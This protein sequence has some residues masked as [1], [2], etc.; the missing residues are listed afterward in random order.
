MA[1][2]GVR[3]TQ[4]HHQPLIMRLMIQSHR[5]SPSGR[6]LSASSLLP[7]TLFNRAP[8]RWKRRHIGH[9]HSRS[10]I[11]KLVSWTY[12]YILARP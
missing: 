4:P 9:A 3:A 12:V 10:I 11:W 5:L 7:V 2:Q 8:E 6:S 1:T